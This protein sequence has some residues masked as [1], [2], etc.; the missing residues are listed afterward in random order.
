MATHRSTLVAGMLVLA[1]L[2]SL[3][4]SPNHVSATGP[5]W[6][7]IPSPNSNLQQD[8]FLVSISGT[9]NDLVAVGSRSANYGEGNGNRTLIE[10]WDGSSWS[11]MPSPNQSDPSD[12]SGDHLT[13]VVATSYLPKVGPDV[14]RNTAWAVGS[15]VQQ[16]SF[17]FVVRPSVLHR[18]SCSVTNA[19]WVTDTLP[20]VSSYDT[21]LK[22]VTRD[23]NGNIWAVGYYTG[24][25]GSSYGIAR[26]LVLK[27]TNGVWSQVPS[28]NLGLDYQD[29][30]YLTGVDVDNTGTGIWAVGYHRGTNIYQA[31]SGMALHWDGSNWQTYN[32]DGQFHAVGSSKASVQTRVVG[33]SVIKSQATAYQWDTSNAWHLDRPSAITDTKLLAISYTAN[34]NESFSVGNTCLDPG[35]GQTCYSKAYYNSGTQWTD[36]NSE[37]SDPSGSDVVYQ[38]GVKVFSATDVW[39][40]GAY[41]TGQYAYH[42]LIKHYN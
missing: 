7:I 10:H 21:E 24:D 30:N 29:S 37:A 19:T 22:A 13:G 40:V 1:L 17:P 32:V 39:V 14:C 12:G 35:T 41:R 4:T 11:I 36:L 33:E 18:V 28:P 8:N 38:N 27:L 31:S 16:S 9:S 25:S 3:L 34:T 2:F 26:T 23:T 6:H 15:Y 20:T 5:S 42:T